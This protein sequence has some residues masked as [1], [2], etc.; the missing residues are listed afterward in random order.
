M[1]VTYIPAAFQDLFNQ[2]FQK[3]KE[4]KVSSQPVPRYEPTEEGDGND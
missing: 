1:V 2:L 3:R 4:A